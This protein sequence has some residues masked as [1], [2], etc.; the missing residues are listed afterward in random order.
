MYKTSINK[1]RESGIVR[2][3]LATM[4]II[5]VSMTI[6]VAN[7]KADTQQVVTEESQFS[8]S[9]TANAVYND[10]TASGGKAMKLTKNATGTL[11]STVPQVSKIKVTA[12][13]DQ[14]DA[15]PIMQI[16]LDDAVVATQAVSATTWTEYAFPVNV[17]AGSHKF[18]VSFTNE[19]TSYWLWNTL[20][21]RALHFDKMT[22]ETNPVVTPTPTPTPTPSPT[23]T[24]TPTPSPSPSPT[25]SPTPTPTPSPVTIPVGSEYVALG[26]SYGSG[27]GA[28]R[29]PAN[30]TI[31]NTVYEGTEN[32]CG[33]SNKAAQRLIAADLQL[34]LKNVSC[35]GANTDNLL[36]TGQAN[37]P[38]QLT[39]LTTNTKLITMTIGGNDTAL[40]WMLFYCVQSGDCYR[41][42]GNWIVDSYIAQTDA[43]IAALEP[44]ME[45][46]LRTA[47]QKSP[48]AKI[49]PTG[50]PNI[51]AAPGEPRGTC[52]AWLSA[53][54][55]I[56]FA[57]ATAQTNDAIKRAANAIALETGKDIKFVDPLATTSPFMTRD[58]GQML[59]G[60]STSLKRYMNGTNDGYTGGW[61]PNILGQKMYADLFKS[62][63]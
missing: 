59:D 35:G 38:A 9:S 52:S 32:T 63:F 8:W 10:T 58:N 48:N 13:G 15:A 42:T 5:F 46:V 60:C 26:D 22:L 23:P 1:W 57:Q 11:T 33:R 16:K 41:G 4:A 62:S 18:Q 50:Y 7:S 43:K 49:R 34:T 3:T 30:L 25:P 61:H 19:F 39:N 54:E 21:V 45:T 47:V 37:E 24:S 6:L 44:K 20:C 51:I 56:Y 27:W 40:M 53:N 55:Q 2:I 14:C 36:T 12:K 29:T 17:P 31:D 28:D